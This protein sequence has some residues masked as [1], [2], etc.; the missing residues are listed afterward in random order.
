LTEVAGER[1]IMMI[2]EDSEAEVICLGDIDATITSKISF[3]IL[4]P[5]RR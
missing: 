3:G 5:P 1:V 4:R 2:A